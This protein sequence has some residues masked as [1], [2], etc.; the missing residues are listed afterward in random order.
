MVGYLCAEVKEGF[1]VFG[2][3]CYWDTV[4]EKG[5]EQGRVEACYTI[6]EK[7]A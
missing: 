5:V 1:L 4:V 6:L 3:R 7:S 2:S